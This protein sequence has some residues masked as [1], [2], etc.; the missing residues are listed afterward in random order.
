MGLSAVLY[1]S[2]FPILADLLYRRQVERLAVKMNTD[3]S[4]GAGCYSLFQIIGIDI[5]S[6][7]V[8]ICEDRA[9][10]FIEG[11][12]CGSNE[13]EGGRYDLIARL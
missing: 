12:V 6:P 11:A 5:E 1:Q 10:A 9:Q 2:N 13:G 4:P 3:Y 7:R 8:H